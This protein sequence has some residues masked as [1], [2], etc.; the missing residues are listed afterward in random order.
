MSYAKLMFTGLFL[1][2]GSAL[3]Q[4]HHL[5][6]LVIDTKGVFDT[7]GRNELISMVSLKFYVFVS[8]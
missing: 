7:I 6:C 1:E 8:I 2:S 4:P 3:A 5:V